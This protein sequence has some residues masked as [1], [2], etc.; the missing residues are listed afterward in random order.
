LQVAL[1]ARGGPF[2]PELAELE[3]L[4]RLQLSW[5]GL[6]H[7]FVLGYF[8]VAF[9][10]FGLKLDLEL[11]CSSWTQY[12]LDWLDDKKL[13]RSCL[14]LV[15]DVGVGLR[16]LDIECGLWHT[17]VGA[18]LEVNGNSVAYF[19]EFDVCHALYIL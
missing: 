5:G 2:F 8:G 13:W 7:E 16:V 1:V 19:N 9:K 3:V 4:A 17:S 11:H 15:C 14:D 18:G 6:D 10:I 12:S